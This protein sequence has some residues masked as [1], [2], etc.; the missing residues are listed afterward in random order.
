MGDNVQT[1]QNDENALDRLYGLIRNV[2]S[3]LDI[4]VGVDGLILLG[5][6]PEFSELCE[7]LKKQGGVI[8]GIIKSPIQNYPDFQSILNSFTE[9]KQLDNIRGIIAT[10]ESEYIN[11]NC[12][13]S[14]TIILNGYLQQ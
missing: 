13:T 4:V 9:I 6:C 10:S 7:Q 5:S 3:R 11:L 8:R 2:K 12:N 1:I 14:G